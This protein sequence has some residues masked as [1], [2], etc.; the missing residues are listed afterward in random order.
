M[1]QAQRIGSAGPDRPGGR[2]RQREAARRPAAG[3]VGAEPFH[4]GAGRQDLRAVHAGDRAR[5]TH[6]AG[7]W[8]LPARG[9][10][11]HRRR[12]RRRR[13]GRHEEEDKKGAADALA[14]SVRGSLLHRPAAPAAP[15]QPQRLRRAFAVPPGEYDVYI[16]VRETPGRR[17]RPLRLAAMPPGPAA[18]K[19]G[20]IKQA[21]SRCRVSTG[22]SSRRAASSS[23]RRWTC[24][25]RRWRT[26]HQAENPYTFGQMKISPPPSPSSPRR[27]TLNVVFWIYGAQ[28]DDTTKKPDVTMD[29]KFYQKTGDKETYFNKTEP[30][31]LNAQTLPPQFDLAAGHQL[32]GSLRGAAGQ[33]PGRRLPARDRG[34]RTR[35]SS[36]TITR[37][38]TFTVAAAVARDRRRCGLPRARGR[39]DGTRHD[40]TAF[41]VVVA[42]AVVGLAGRGVRERADRRND[43]RM[44][45]GPS[46]TQASR[47]G[48]IHRQ[49]RARRD[50]APVS[51]AIVSAV[52]GR[53]PRARP[54]RT[55]AARSR[56]SPPATTGAGAPR[57][58]R[59]RPQPRR[60]R[61]RR[62]SSRRTIVVLKPH[63]ERLFPEADRLRNRRSSP[64]ASAPVRWCRPPRP[65]PTL[66]S[67]TRS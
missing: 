18:S 5:G 34:W 32:P 19:S 28:V 33:L 24:C 39:S 17:G 16:A 56:R 54:T 66:P 44:A 50:G 35:R 1:E 15:G 31:V 23:R 20:V 55:A 6:H 43:G 37:D 8:R 26:D 7:R 62:G 9:G 58:F 42:A 40:H 48:R 13:T 4:Q 25:R 3:E 67:W 57:R 21:I 36:K 65:T 52:G 29:F 51:G 64:P 27:T 60:P 49:P 30:Q 14:V 12:S 38:V 11:G 45:H 10:E 41:G 63:R 53:T 2:L 22:A 47:S 59:R 61:D 46:M